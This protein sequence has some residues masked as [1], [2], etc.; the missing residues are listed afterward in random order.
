[1]VGKKLDEEIIIYLLKQL[2]IIEKNSNLISFDQ[3][4]TIKENKKK[5]YLTDI[6][7][8]KVGTLI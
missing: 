1:V 6:I 7:I 2:F 8:K 3:S 5:R 4:H